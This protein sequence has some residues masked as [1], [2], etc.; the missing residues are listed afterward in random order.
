MD[1]AEDVVLRPGAGHREEELFAA[2]LPIQIGVSRP[3][4]DE[5]VDIGRDSD[6]IITKVW[7]CRDAI[8]LDAVELHTFVLQIYDT[9]WNQIPR[10]CCLL[11][12]YAVMVAGDENSELCR[13]GTVPFKKV[14]QVGGVEAFAGISGTDEDVGINGYGEP[15]LHHMGV[16][17]GENLMT[18]VVDEHYEG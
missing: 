8:E 18:A 16:R 12:E 4:R 17:E 13:D 7:P 10:S 6:L 1:V 5:E 15:P 14:L 9:T 3:V 2:K 11:V